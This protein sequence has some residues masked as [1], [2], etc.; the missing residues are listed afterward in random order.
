MMNDDGDRGDHPT[1]AV[2]PEPR[3]GSDLGFGYSDSVAGHGS[4]SDLG[5]PPSQVI[6]VWVWVTG[7]R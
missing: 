7:R 2:A 4:S 5:A 6:E 1:A 3:S